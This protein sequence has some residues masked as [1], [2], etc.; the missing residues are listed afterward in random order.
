MLVSRVV[1]VLS[2]VAASFARHDPLVRRQDDSTPSTSVNETDVT[3]KR[4]IV[5]FDQGT[6]PQ[7]AADE[8]ANRPGVKV[9]KVFNSDIFHGASL[10]TSEDNLDTL[11]AEDPVIQAWQA[12][13]VTLAPITPLQSFGKDAAGV[14]LSIHHMTGVDKLH[15]KGV[16]G[17]GAVVAVVDTGVDYTHSA[18]GGGIGKGFKIAGGYDLVGNGEWPD[19]P[20]RQP[21]SDPMDQLGHGTHV[22]GIIAGESDLLTGVAPEATLRVYKVFATLDA[23]TEDVLIE[24]FLLAYRDGADVITSSVGGLAGWLD[25]A[26]AVV[27]SRLVD[28]GVVVTISAGND[29]QAGAFAASSGSS[30][31]HVL[32]IASVEADI[33]PTPSF[34]ATFSRDGDIQK[35]S[36]PY[37]SVEDWYPSEID[38]WPI[39][40][41]GLD[42]GTADEACNTLPEDTQNFTNSVVL[43]RRGGCNFSQKQRNL[44]EFGGL[45]VLIYTNDMPIVMPTTD[46]L[47]GQI[48]MITREA[49]AEI[50]KTIKAGGNV[51]ADFTTRPIFTLTGLVNEET[52]GEA[53]YFTTIGATNDLYVKYDIA[54]PGGQILSSYLG[55][56]YSVLSGTSMACPYVAGIAALYIG[57]HGGRSAHGPDFAKELAMRIISS[58][59]SIPWSDGTGDGTDYGFLASVAQVGT[60]LVNATKV[61]D[62]STSLSFTKFALND[63]RKFNKR[64]TIDITNNGKKPITYT[65]SSEDFGGLNAMNIDPETWGTPRI[66]W[67]EEVLAAPAKM[68]PTISF[69]GG[70]FTVKPGET[71][72]AKFAFKAPSGLDASKLPLYSGKVVIS[73]NNG[74]SLAVPYLGLAADLEKD[75]GDI[76]QYP[77]GFPTITSTRDEIPISEKSNFTFD[78]DP[79]VQDFPN[80]YTRLNFGTRELRW[81]IFDS[82]WTER[83]W[84]YPPAVGKA[85]YVGAATSWAKLSGKQ[86]FNATVDDA[87]EVITMPMT[88]VP[89]S[90]VGVFGTELWWLGRLANGTQIAPGKYNMRFAALKPFGNPRS[91]DHWDV[92]DTPSFEVLPLET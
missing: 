56:G 12:K 26:W 59:D 10:E 82:K 36:V 74:E 16:L 80:L 40:P 68:V 14:N 9:L 78:L 21:D 22:S 34:N 76:F 84:K 49:G 35:I 73:G 13:R 44:A 55:G 70:K 89:R 18:L 66:A 7:A 92:F 72:K 69:P 25:N 45:K 77:I 28:E 8:L 83:K 46:F 2:S 75:V 54:A 85:G 23:T 30:G 11:K 38:G 19:D 61:L 53:S 52:G 58:G 43:V 57:Q 5:E 27:A 65:F 91:S 60:G 67:G 31:E 81:D 1:L 17:K 29:G 33:T 42:T 64:H 86:F 32:A 88:D 87:D 24:A 41:L 37:R 48:A 51:T 62:Y 71:K 6:N 20:E 79:D 47:D 90:I 3:P 63:T 15:A 50:I 39:I 4:F